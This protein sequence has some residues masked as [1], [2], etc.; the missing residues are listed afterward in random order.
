MAPIRAK[1]LRYFKDRNVRARIA[2]PPELASDGYADRPKPLGD[3][4]TGYV[5]APDDR[6]GH[7]DDIAAED[8]GG[9]QQQRQPA[10]DERSVEVEPAKQLEHHDHERDDHDNA[11]DKRAMD[12]GRPSPDRGKPLN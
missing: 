2:P 12:R 6:L 3:D 9:L 7:N 11:A 1:K 8:D 4:W 10:L 5:R